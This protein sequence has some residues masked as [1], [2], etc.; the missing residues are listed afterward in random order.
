MVELTDNK[1]K[2]FKGLYYRRM[3]NNVTVVIDPKTG[4]KILVINK[5]YFHPEHLAEQDKI[6]AKEAGLEIDE[7]ILMASD[8]IEIM[9]NM[10]LK[11][12]KDLLI[13]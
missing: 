8:E 13:G 7:K 10:I 3:C 2:E 12:K 6:D 9:C 1:M 5:Q 4:C 11:V